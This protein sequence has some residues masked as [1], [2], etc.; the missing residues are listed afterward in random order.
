MSHRVQIV[1]PDVIAARLEE[2][3]HTASEPV[4]TLAAR[5]VR[6]GVERAPSNGK[7][8]EPGASSS[9]AETADRRPPWLEPYGGDEQWRRETWG[10][11]VA[12][13]GRY[14]RHLAHLKDGWWKDESTTETLA[15]LAVWR[16]EIDSSGR[17]PRE[18]LAFHHQLADYAHTLHKQGGG[19]S[20]TWQPG[21]PPPEFANDVR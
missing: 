15:A 2:M 19:V 13:P 8:T 9:T 7:T 3:A 1:I 14:P 18:E 12:L 10:A 5:I 20:Q 6:D 17:D 4:A 16:S 21:P 11:I